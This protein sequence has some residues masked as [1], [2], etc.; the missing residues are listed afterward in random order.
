[1][2]EVWIEVLFDSEPM[3]SVIA[4]NEEEAKEIINSIKQSGFAKYYNEE[5]KK[6]WL[7]MGFRDNPEVTAR[8]TS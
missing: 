1:M 3:D 7:E 6:E 2:E 4:D 5:I 8:I